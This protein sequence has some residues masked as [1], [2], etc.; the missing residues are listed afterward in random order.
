[1]YIYH[2]Q[3][4]VKGLPLVFFHGWQQDSRSFFSLVPFLHQDY[5]LFFLDLPGF[6]QSE[7]PPL[8]FSSFDYAKAITNWLKKRNLK[9]IVLIGHSFG[10]KIAA[11]ISAE[12][13]KVVNK[14]I[15]IASSGVSHP[16]IVSNLVKIIPKKTLEKIPNRL[17]MFFASRD[18]KEAGLLLPIFKRVVKEDIHPIFAKIKIPTLIIW[19]KRDQELPSQDGKVIQGL[20][21][22]SKLVLIEGDHFPFWQNPQKIAKLIKNFIAK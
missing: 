19:G 10:G 14:L 21:K 17:K 16:R 3:F 6:G 2:F 22:K 15:L 11:I 18:Y 4:G 13:P 5:R 1:V 9:Q 8:S 12:N 7:N 20:I